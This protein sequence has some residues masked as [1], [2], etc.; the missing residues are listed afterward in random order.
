MIKVNED[1]CIKCG[2]CVFVCPFNVI[3]MKESF[4]KLNEKKKCIECLHCA[5]TCPEDAIL[6][7]E[8]VPILEEKAEKMADGYSE[9][10]RKLIL[11]RRS[12]RNFTKKK[13]DRKIIEES[14]Q[15]A[16]WVPSAKN[17]HFNKWL[18]IESE[19]I[20]SEMMN[21]ILDH[22]K[23]SKTSLEVVSEYEEGNNVVMGTSKTLI[24]GY[25]QSDAVNA[26]G[27]TMIAMTT[28]ELILQSKNIGT[29]WA[30]YLTRFCNGIP[31]VRE[32]LKE[33]PEGSNIYG[34]FM[35]GYPDEEYV[36]I[37]A[38]VRE[39]DIKYI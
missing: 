39:S 1:K 12:Y 8:E 33:I 27:D 20:I 32:M 26:V 38:R 15:L 36:N 28:L 6:Y 18:V 10:L 4:P 7:N 17:Q 11:N 5:A 34:A 3:E 25:C 16:A 21:A 37:P 35:L 30:G 14:L 19:E 29:C 2:K 9:D 31:K 23:E 13:V 24:L 22:C